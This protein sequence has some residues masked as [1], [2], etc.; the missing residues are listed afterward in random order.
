MGSPNVIGSD[1]NFVTNLK[2]RRWGPSFVSRG[3]VA[4]LGFRDCFPEFLVELIEVHYK[5]SCSCG[6]EV[7]FGVY[8]DVWMVSLVGKEG[9]Y[10]SSGVRSIVVRKLHNR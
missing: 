1:K 2:V 4:S 10:T 6:A 5:V 3:R 9:G 7:S 8:R